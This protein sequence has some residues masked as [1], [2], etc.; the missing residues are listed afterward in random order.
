MIDPGGIPQYTGDF[1]ELSKAVSEFRTRAVGI[2]NDGQDVHS[3]FQ[4]TAAYYKAPEADQLFSSTQP[5]M[6]TA[7]EFA[8]HIESL[9]DALETFTAEAKPHADR[10]KALREKASAFV[11]SVRGDEDW[12]KDQDKFDAHKALMDGVAEAVDGFQTAERDAASKIDRISPGACRPSWVVDDGSHAP[13]MYGV[14]ADTLTSMDHLP[15]GSPE[16][17]SYERWSLDWWK[18]GAKSWAWDGIVKDSVWGG[19]VGL[20]VL[21]DNLLGINGAQA[22]G[23][24][25]DGLRRTVVGAYAYGMD[26]VG[27][28]D[29]L[30]DWQRNSEAYADEFG[31]GFVAYDTWDEDPAR[32]HAVTA[33]NL[34]TLFG[35]AAGGLAKVGKAGRAADTAGALARAG[36]ALDPVSGGMRAAE[37]LSDLPKISDVLA[38][39]S[40][41]LKLPKPHLPD[42]ALDLNDRYRIAKDGKL[43]PLHADG[44]PNTAPAVREP[45]AA[46][47]VPSVRTGDRELVGAG[48]W[49]EE[50]P[51]QE[52]DRLSPHMS[53]ETGGGVPDGPRGAGAAPRGDEAGGVHNHLGRSGTESQGLGGDGPHGAGGRGQSSSGHPSTESAHEVAPHDGAPGNDPYDVAGDVGASHGVVPDVDPARYAATSGEHSQ[54]HTGPIKPEQEA[55]VLDELKHA[56]MDSRDQEAV[57]RSLRK[58]PYGAGVAEIINRGNLRGVENYREI[59]DMYKKGPTRRDPKESMVPA[60]YMA[61]IHAEELQSRGDTRLGFELGDAGTTYDIDVYTR[62]PDGAMDYGYQL[63]D[64]DSVTGIRKAAKKSASQLDYP[65]SHRV[66]VLDVHDTMGNLTPRIFEE[67]VRAA[68]RSNATYLLRFEDGAITVPADGPVFP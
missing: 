38:R 66:A 22:R 63:K 5:V 44:T 48:R 15:W 46:A 32:A 62:Y 57:L 37:G 64:V 29:H 17:R 24:T 25:W 6:D 18:H 41:H 65:M 52:V 23:D 4:A 54:A 61:L 55:G 53:H 33:F 45:S 35:G 30:S 14:H 40:D 31:K 47:R 59:L 21:E 20:G 16:N 12:S 68:G 10:L 50:A 60:A 34:L 7:D 11:D 43:V 67:V 51:A 13:G 36:D 1:T 27:L 19:F 9:A 3:R 56:K 26:A 8:A 58:D 39:V 42:T 28:G 49:T 2:R